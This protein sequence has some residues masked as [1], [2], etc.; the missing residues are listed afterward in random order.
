MASSGVTI[1]FASGD[2]GSRPDPTTGGYEEG[3]FEQVGYPASD[4]SVTGVGG[5][6]LVASNPYGTSPGGP[7]YGETVWFSNGGASG[8]GVSQDFNRPSWQVGEGVPAGTKRLVPDVALAADPDDGAL[9]V[10]NGGSSTIGGTSWSSPAWA[11]YCAL[12]NQ[13]RI[14]AGLG[15]IGLLN[16]KIYPLIGSN[17]FQ[18]ITV[19]NNG[20]YFAGPG[21]D[22]CTGVGT[23]NVG[24]LVQ[25]LSLASPQTIAPTI[26]VQPVGQTINGGQNATFTVVA[27]SFSATTYQWQILTPGSSAWTD[28]TDNGSFSGSATASL[29]IT[30]A[31]TGMAGDQFQCVVRNAAGTV[32]SASAALTVPPVEPPITQVF[33]N[34]QQYTAGSSVTLGSYGS[35]MGNIPGPITYQWYHNGQPIPGATYSNYS[36]SSAAYADAGEYILAATNPGGTAT[37]FVGYVMITNP[38]NASS[39][40]D[41]Q[42]QGNIVY[43]LY[44]APAQILRYDLNAGSWLA[45][46]SLSGTPTALRV[47]AEGVYVGF[48]RTTS[49]YSLDL[50]TATPLINTEYSTTYIFLNGSYAY[51]LGTDGN[52][53]VYTS[54]E[55]NGGASV[56]TSIGNY[57]NSYFA[58][59]DVSEALNLAY[60][61]TGGDSSIVA[62]SL[63]SDGT[64]TAANTPYNPNALNPTATKVYVF[65]GGL[66]VA[67]NGGALYN[68][69]TLAY[70][71]T[72]GP[73]FDDLCFLGD[74]NPVV[75]RGNEV[76]LYGAGNLKELG[77][78]ALTGGAPR[79]FSS[80][81]TV[82]GFSPPNAAGGS[83]AVQSVTEAQLAGSTRQSGPVVAPS[84]ISFIPD[85][86]FVGTDGQLYLLAR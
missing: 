51:L 19:G 13:A 28:V 77:R 75:V 6:I 29:L 53:G 39:W 67:N 34:F 85:D 61:E 5:T 24:V 22:E 69:S 17:C 81:T 70:A 33:G 66:Q 3:G 71:G 23:P 73:A 84:S 32:T 7:G 35:G 68:A 42:Q 4:L 82:V 1:F 45:P 47:A 56:A 26:A 11:G 80:G 36:I 20:D 16:P 83:I 40:L 14:A 43:F 15:P 38:V 49:L 10:L 9:I 30:D 44:A 55:R 74:G 48:G 12:F 62:M 65:P 63:N 18:D 31:T 76:T 41:A 25:A 59:M 60:G 57:Y 72:L 54:L 58:Q 78:V 46:V 8:G 86:G 50:S 52:Q 2:G 21:Y 64:V 27:N 79:I 37:A